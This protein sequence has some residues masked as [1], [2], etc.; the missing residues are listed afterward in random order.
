MGIY[1]SSFERPILEREGSGSTVLI[2]I[3]LFTFKSYKCPF[4]IINSINCP[5]FSC[6]P[7]QHLTSS[8]H[9]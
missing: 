9:V 7:K 1:V 8:C 4:Y 6:I 3:Y 5:H 2:A